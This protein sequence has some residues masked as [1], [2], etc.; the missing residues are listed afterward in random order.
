LSSSESELEVDTAQ[1]D[2][3]FII[4]GAGT[5]IIGSV[6]DVVNGS[7]ALGQQ[8]N[9][10]PNATIK[11]PAVLGQQNEIRAGAYLRGYTLIGNNGCFRGELKKVV[12]MD[13][14]QF[15]HPS[16]VGDSICGY[17]S[18]FGN[19]VTTANISIFG[20]LRVD[21]KSIP[22]LKVVFDGRTFQ[23]DRFKMGAIVGDFAQV[24]CS[25]VLAPA[26]FL[27]PFTVTYPL[28]LLPGGVY[29]PFELIKNKPLRESHFGSLSVIERSPLLIPPDD[30][31]LS[32]L[33]AIYR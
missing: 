13:H 25:S 24:G 1:S 8:N 17:K 11:G 15:P 20:G 30:V 23:L 31:E 19:Q 29:G 7:I 3:R 2:R 32:Q 21:E 10:E 28:V 5:R 14:V 4:L 26:S 18:H 9:V 16:Y 33:S 27:R 12:M 6:L 22:S